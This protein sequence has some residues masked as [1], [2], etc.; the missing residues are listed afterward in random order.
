MIARQALGPTYQAGPRRP[1]LAAT[2]CEGRR[3]SCS[4][5]SDVWRDSEDLRDAPTTHWIGAR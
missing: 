2:P 5:R 3:W 4:R 1:Q